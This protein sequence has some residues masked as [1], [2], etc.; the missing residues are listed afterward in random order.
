MNLRTLFRVKFYKMFESSFRWI[1]FGIVIAT[2]YAEIRC[3]TEQ[4]CNCYL[5][6][7]GVFEIQCPTDSY[8]AFVVKVKLYERIGIECVNF[9]K[10][11]DFPTNVL[12]PE[13]VTLLYFKMCEL[14]VNQSLNEISNK[15]GAQN[16][17]KLIFHSYGKLSVLNRKHLQG[18]P[19]LEYLSLTCNNLTNFSNDIF[20]D[21]PRLKN[22]NLRQNN[23][24]SLSEIFN[25]I[26]N[27]EILEL[28]DNKLKEIDVNTFKPLKALKML[29]MWGNKFTEFKSNIF[30]NLV[31]LN[32]L[33]VSS[34]HLNTLPNDIFAKLVNLKLLHLAWN[35]FSSLPEGLLQHNVKLNKVKLSNNRISMK[36]LPNGL[37]ANLKNLKEIELNNNDLIELPDL[38]HDSISLEIIDLSFNNLESLPEYLFANLVNLTK[39]IISNNKLTSLPDGIFSKLKKLIILDLSHNNL[40]S[41]SR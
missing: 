27:L 17:E 30:D 31:S 5:S 35:N 13:N 2:C 4:N 11:I 28:G 8:S 25:Y 18:F 3:P 23:I 9:P 34:N 40:T 15:L 39:L 24:Y 6:P 20:A 16:I 22:L 7:E 32:S 38:F 29:N 41:I 19:N 37:F 10:W 14:P 1:I 21:V 12:P 36:T 33:D 26:P